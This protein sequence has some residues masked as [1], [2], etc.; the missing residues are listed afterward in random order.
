MEQM[1]KPPTLIIITGLPCTGKS[2]LGRFLARGLSLPYVSKDGI[3]EILF[4]TLGFSDRAWS[5]QL[6]LA[7][8]A[9]LYYF[10]DLELA[11]G[12]SL[13]VESNFHAETAGQELGRLKSN[14]DFRV[15][16]VLCYCESSIL[17]ERFER[18][19]ASSERH[20]GHVEQENLEEFRAVL[21]SSRCD[22]LPIEGL[23]IEL[24][25]T[26]FTI[27]NYENVLRQ[28]RILMSNSDANMCWQA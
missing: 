11:A 18:R 4:D 5:R 2:T 1:I 8:Y 28:I 13:I 22:P 23:V 9:L 20:P 19:A 26:D 6:G 10:L 27:V 17:L 7:S 15:V 16:Q 14:Y 24:D 12:R 25:T 3:K 21:D